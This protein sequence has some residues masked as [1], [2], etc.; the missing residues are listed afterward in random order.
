MSERQSGDYNRD[1]TDEYLASLYDVSYPPERRADFAFYLPLIVSAGAVLDVGCG[2]GALLRLARE[3]GHRGRLCGLDP[4][5]GMLNQARIRSDIEWVLGDLSTARWE[6]EFDLA[7]T[8]GHAFQELITDDEIRAALTAIRAAL[9]EGGRFA[10]ETRN[11]LDRAWER[12]PAQYSGTVTDAAGAVVRRDYRVETPVEGNVVCSS[13]TFTSPAWERPLVSRGGLRFIDAQ[14]LAA[15]L[16]SADL[17][18]EEQFGDWDR[19]PFDDSS[20]EI[21]TIARRA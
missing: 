1:F 7:V 11:P 5:P 2:T 18:I 17:A 3:A 21:I 13:C 15:F 19:R 12:W 4:A 10:F 20:P 16:S 14:A 9:V 8:T 6:R